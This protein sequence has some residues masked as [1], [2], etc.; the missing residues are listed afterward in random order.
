MALLN[1]T[2]LQGRNESLVL[3]REMGVL[4]FGPQDGEI[5]RAATLKHQF[6]FSPLVGEVPRTQVCVAFEGTSGQG[7]TDPQ[8]ILYFSGFLHLGRRSVRVTEGSVDGELAVRL[9]RL[10]PEKRVRKQGVHGLGRVEVQ[11]FTH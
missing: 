11:L 3:A 5:Q 7:K 6:L 1:F 8:P 9:M 10:V 2:E 4:S